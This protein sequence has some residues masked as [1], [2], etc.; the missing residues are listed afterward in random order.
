MF[1]NVLNALQEC[2]VWG[3]CNRGKGDTNHQAPIYASEASRPIG[4][5]EN[6]CSIFEEESG[7]SVIYKYVIAQMRE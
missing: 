2:I 7:H 1:V 5:V 4:N 6:S 3:K